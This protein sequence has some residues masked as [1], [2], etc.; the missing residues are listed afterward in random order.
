MLPYETNIYHDV[1]PYLNTA[2]LPFAQQYYSVEEFDMI[3]YSQ[4][5]KEYYEYDTYMSALKDEEQRL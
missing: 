1:P 2:C 3:R 5:T 4:R